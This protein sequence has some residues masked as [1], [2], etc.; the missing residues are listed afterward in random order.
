MQFEHVIKNPVSLIIRDDICFDGWSQIG[1]AIEVLEKDIL[2][3]VV[4][5][6]VIRIQVA[7]HLERQILVWVDLK[8]VRLLHG[9]KAYIG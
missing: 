4:H 7:R 1:V 6:E 5:L 8:Q 3:A 9:N 2:H